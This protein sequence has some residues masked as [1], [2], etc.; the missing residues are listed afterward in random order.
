MASPEAVV[1]KRSLVRA[2]LVLVAVPMWGRRVVVA[3]QSL[4]RAQPEPEPERPAQASGAR[5]LAPPVLASGAR[6][7]WTPKVVAS[8]ELRSL[9]MVAA[10]AE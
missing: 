5:V 3:Q 7:V 1:A 4:G 2:V 8:G 6:A 10:V 9:P